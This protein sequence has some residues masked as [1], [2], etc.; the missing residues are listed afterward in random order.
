[1]F[2]LRYRPLWWPM[3]EPQNRGTG[4]VVPFRARKQRTDPPAGRFVPESWL[5][6]E[7]MVENAAA[8][9]QAALTIDQIARS[10]PSSLRKVLDSMNEASPEAENCPI[11]RLLAVV[12]AQFEHALAGAPIDYSN[13]KI[14][15]DGQYWLEIDGFAKLCRIQRCSDGTL[16]VWA[17]ATPEQKETFRHGQ[18]RVLG[19]VV[20]SG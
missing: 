14:S 1:M 18:L 12:C 11:A 4:I 16:N 9:L 17:D 20:A 2:P 8:S 3:V 15:G 13:G 6:T 10:T 19:R 5:A 7:S